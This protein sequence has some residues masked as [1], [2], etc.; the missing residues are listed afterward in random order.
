MIISHKYRFIFVKTAKVAGTSLEMALR[1]FLGQND[2]S[3]PVVSYDE[4][5]AKRNGIPCPQNYENFFKYELITERFGGRGGFNEHSWAYEI[6]GIVGDEIWKDYYT[7]TIERD[8]RE[9]SVSNYF[10]YRNEKRGLGFIRHG[11]SYVRPMVKS[12]NMIG[13]TDIE[14]SK[15]I[16]SPL[17]AKTCGLDTWLRI[18]RY[19]AF[20]QNIGRYTINGKV[21]V[22]KVFSYKRM[23]ELVDVLQDILKQKLNMP[24]LK[25]NF[26]PKNI[27]V[28]EFLVEKLLDNEI[29]KRE[30]ELLKDLN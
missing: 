20:A 5:F 27:H 21:I 4:E 18:D 22:D 11:V 16:R 26:K 13:K 2:I 9:K 30:Y 28:N 15:I 24:R 14:R 3:T 17:I 23:E 6:K 7:F 12:L 25:S 8:P 1:P 10:H 29:Y 19:A